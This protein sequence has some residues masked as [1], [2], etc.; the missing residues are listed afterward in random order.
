MRKIQQGNRPST[1]M[2]LSDRVLA[3]LL[4]PLFFNLALII[5]A[6]VVS[7]RARMLAS[8]M[9]VYT[10]TGRGSILFVVLPAVVGFMAGSAGTAK[11]LGH[12]FWTH[13]EPERN[14]SHTLAVWVFL[15]GCLYLALGGI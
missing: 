5:Y 4:F 7:R 1:R 15:G 10:V 12:A 3:A 8:L 14:I 6:V 13:A 11:L 2:P 9:Y